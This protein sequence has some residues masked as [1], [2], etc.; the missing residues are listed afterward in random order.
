MARTVKKPGDPSQPPPPG[1]PAPAPSPGSVPDP[2]L[3]PPAPRAPSL[4]VDLK[5]GS[6]VTAADPARGR[7][8]RC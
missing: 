2:A 8:A 6:Q 3:A 7:P 1:Q 4:N 5:D